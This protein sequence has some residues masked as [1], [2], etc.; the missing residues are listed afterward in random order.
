MLYL[1]LLTDP[2]KYTEFYFTKL[3]YKEDKDFF[4]ESFQEKSLTSFLGDLTYLFIKHPFHAEEI[5]AYIKKNELKYRDKVYVLDPVTITK[6]QKQFYSDV[7]G[8]YK[9]TGKCDYYDEIK[10]NSAFWYFTTEDESDLSIMFMDLWYEG[11]KKDMSEKEKDDFMLKRL[12]K[13]AFPEK[14][15]K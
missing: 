13:A 12:M 3:K 7:Y 15:G 5:T 9:E 14:K 10:S 11:H 8:E 6:Y 4:L 2:E 1:L